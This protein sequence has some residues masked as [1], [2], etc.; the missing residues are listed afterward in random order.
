MTCAEDVPLRQAY[1]KAFCA[2]NSSRSSF[3]RGIRSTETT[4]AF[5]RQILDARVQA[6]NALYYHSLKCADSKV[7]KA[8]LFEDE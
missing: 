5:R 1:D 2:W 7:A 6:A 8:G 3:M 4:L